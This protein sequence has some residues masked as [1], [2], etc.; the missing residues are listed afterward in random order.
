MMSCSKNNDNSPGTDIKQV[1]TEALSDFV[2]VLGKP[3]Y[4]TFVTKATALNDAVEA[5]VTTP[6]TENQTAAQQAW[7][8]TRVVWEQSEGFLIGPVEDDNYDPN[9]DT[10]PTDRN[11]ID[12]M[13]NRN[14]DIDNAFLNNVDGALK[15]F[16]PLEYYLWDFD[17]A[18]YTAEQKKYL[19]AL[20]AN[21]LDNTKALEASW[22]TGGFAE[23]VSN[24]GTSGRYKTQGE[25]L[26]ALANALIDIC[27]EVGESKMPTPFGPP[28][29]STQTE[30]P[31]SHN[32]I[33]DFKNNITGAL[34]SY[35]CTYN[36]K[37]GKSLSAL[38]QINNRNLDNQIK[39]AFTAAINSFDGLKNTTFEK[40][41]YDS[42]SAVQNTIDAIG[43]LQSLLSEQ[44][45]PYIQKY[46][47]N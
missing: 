18:K 24:A 28:A 32:S 1:Q 26:E 43:A 23:E 47:K 14:P 10:W 35:T 13:L 46:V 45:V 38:V 6:T 27:H 2:N 39:Q 33:A 4:A 44:L 41:I 22:T 5:L 17:P 12:S 20:A 34:N 37:T 21:I 36:G 11:T 25:A 29:D 16:H 7:V 15:G 30:S 9:M 40:A 19:V 8:A 31:Y 3:L 42:R